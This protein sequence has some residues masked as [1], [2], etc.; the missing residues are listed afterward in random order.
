[1]KNTAKDLYF[2][3]NCGKSSSLLILYC[4]CGKYETYSKRSAEKQGF[5]NQ[6]EMF[7]WIWNHREHKSEISGRSLD[8][9]PE[10]LFLNM[11]SHILSKA[12]GKYP[13]FKLNEKNIAL[14]L[15][16][17]HSLWDSGTIQQRLDYEKKYNCS[18]D[19]MFERSEKLKKEYDLFK[20]DSI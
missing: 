7:L 9:V 14:I 20:K 6:L 8:T 18:F 19:I 13:L 16:E 4:P 15:P 11:F 10:H 1:M 2:C 5:D 12:M 3:S 17:E